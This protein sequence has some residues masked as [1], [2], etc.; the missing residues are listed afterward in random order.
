MVF[1]FVMN[2]IP[3]SSE[4]RSENF[5]G[6]IRSKKHGAGCPAPAR[7]LFKPLLFRREAHQL[8]AAI[9][10]D[11]HGIQDDVEAC[12]V[13]VMEGYAD[14]EADPVGAFVLD[15]DVDVQVVF[16]ALV[17]VSHDVLLG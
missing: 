3:S 2:T 5:K 11:G 10:R 17:V 15:F 7:W 13:F 14:A 12:T 6:T 1:E 8:D 9:Y 16:F 4:F